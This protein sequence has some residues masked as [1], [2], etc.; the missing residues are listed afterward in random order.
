MDKYILMHL[1]MDNGSCVATEFE[2]HARVL[3]HQG[4]KI[5]IGYVHNCMRYL[6]SVTKPTDFHT[7]T[8]SLTVAILL[9]YSIQF[10]FQT[11]PRKARSQA[12]NGRRH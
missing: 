2:T 5:V 3:L 4:Y 6:D 10:F 9:S 7:T 1:K 8:A 11:F 12:V